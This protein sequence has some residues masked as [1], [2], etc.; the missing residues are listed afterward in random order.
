MGYCLLLFILVI[1]KNFFKVDK[2][3]CTHRF[4]TETVKPIEKI[5]K[6]KN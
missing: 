2:Y 1:V 4:T 5:L 6:H 3:K